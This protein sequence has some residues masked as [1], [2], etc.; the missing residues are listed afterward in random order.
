MPDTDLGSIT[1]A[2]LNN[3]ALAVNCPPLTDDVVAAAK[4]RRL[5]DELERGGPGARLTVTKEREN[6]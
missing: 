6:V 4:F 5:R 3:A 2:D 1:P